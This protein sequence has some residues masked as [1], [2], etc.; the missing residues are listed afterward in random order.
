MVRTVKA[1]PIS[2]CPL[3]ERAAAAAQRFEPD[4]LHSFTAVDGHMDWGFSYK[5]ATGWGGAGEKAGSEGC[6][7]EL[8]FEWGRRS[9][10]N[11]ITVG[12]ADEGGGGDSEESGEAGPCLRR[13]LNDLAFT[14]SLTAAAGDLAERLGGLTY[15]V[16][17][18]A[19]GGGQMAGAEVEAGDPRQIGRLVCVPS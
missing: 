11:K 9:P 5:P 18:L 16:R 2:L 17:T 8:P 19:P 13:G 7:R 6:S 10:N 15:I 3:E 1:K 14:L 4:P 12:G